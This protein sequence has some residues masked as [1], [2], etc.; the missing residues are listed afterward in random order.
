MKRALAV[1]LLPVLLVPAACGAGSASRPTATP[2]AATDGAP[3]GA[4]SSSAGVAPEPSTPEGVEEVPPSSA[5]LDADG[6]TALPVG[7]PAGR[8]ASSASGVPAVSKGHASLHIDAADATWNADDGTCS[9]VEGVLY[10]SVGDPSSKAASLQFVPGT[11]ADVYLT[12]QTDPEHTWMSNASQLHL[13]LGADLVS[14]TFSGQF[15]SVGVGWR[16]FSGS[17]TCFPGPAYVDGPDEAR[18]FVVEV[19]SCPAD[20]AG[21]RFSAGSRTSDAM[22]IVIDASSVHADGSFEGFVSW[23]RNGV[24]YRSTWMTGSGSPATGF[25]EFE[26]EVVGPDGVPFGVTGG[27]SCLGT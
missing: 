21:T 12:W 15:L 19:G 8:P 14:G 4:E 23:R 13:A 11:G 7:T 26:A 27:F 1:L 16:E 10:L 5:P 24:V 2:S 6:A 20:P 3:V 22:V 17:F 25:V 9:V 18:S